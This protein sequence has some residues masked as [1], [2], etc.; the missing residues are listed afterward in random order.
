M[1][2]VSNAF[3]SWLKSGTNIKLS[4]DAA[5]TRITHEG[6]T[7]Y[8]SLANFD[9]KSIERL[10]QICKENIPAF[11]E[12][13]TNEIQAEPAVNGANISSISIFRLIT[14]SNAVTYYQSID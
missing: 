2:V 7:N 1:V 12:D 9:K 14:A 8:D 6:I 4:S 13:N 5:V 10:P 11:V 3:R